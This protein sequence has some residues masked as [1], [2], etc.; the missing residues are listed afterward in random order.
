MSNARPSG[1]AV[2]ATA[3][4]EMAAYDALPPPLRAALAEAVVA[5][6]AVDVLSRWR[7]ASTRYGVARATRVGVRRVLEARPD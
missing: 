4:A 6:S 1:G 3:A 2:L 5:W 7:R